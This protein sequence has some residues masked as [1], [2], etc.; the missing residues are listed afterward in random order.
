MRAS[1]PCLLGAITLMGCV[2]DLG[3]GGADGLPSIPAETASE[4]GPS[5]MRR[6]TVAEYRRTVAD[7]LEIDPANAATVLPPDIFIPF[8]NDI[9]T[10]KASEGLIKG[11]EILAGDVAEIVAADPALRAPLVGCEP[12]GPGDEACFRSFLERFGRRA[13]R[14]PLTSAEVDRFATLLA[15]GVEEGD[16]Y[17]AV[18]GALRAFLQHPEFLYRVERGTPVANRPGVFA[19]NSFEVASRLSY[20]LVGS[21]PPD[22]L[23]DAAESGEL[24]TAEGVA[25]AARTLFETEGARANVNR[26]HGL[27][28]SYADLATEGIS[29]DLR[30]ETDALVERVVFEEGRPWTDV[31]TM[32]ETFLTEELA[33]HYGLPSPGAEPGWVSYADTGRKGLLSQ[34]AFLSAVAKFGDTSPTQRGLLV[35][36]RLFC[37]TIEKP[38]AELE[39]NV[40]MPPEVDDPDACKV[41][42]YFMAQEE[43]C[44]GC[45]LLMDPI[46]F[47]LENYDAAGRFRETDNGRPECVIDGQGALIGLGLPEDG[48]FEGPAGLADMAVESGKVEACVAKQLYRFA[49]GRFFL[50][51]PDEVLLDRVVE[52]SS[53][54]GAFRFDRFIEEYVGSDAFRYRREESL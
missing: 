44:K 48:A 26:F 43:A 42:R 24:D 27:W 47:G 23:L 11:A 50:E 53:E 30:A 2:G 49:V 31:L 19:L 41:D 13:L 12:S 25:S 7:L 40:D 32:E 20:F 14:R 38:P 34:G 17:F 4:I 22:W 52:A 45:H 9:S 15:F 46:G 10:Q 33:T 21:T 54:S 28:L 6:L 8:D 29:A 51:E 37:E 36:T 16:F 1:T 18:N 5:G 35:R 3:D 39:V